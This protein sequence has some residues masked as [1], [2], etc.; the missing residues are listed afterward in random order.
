MALWLQAGSRGGLH[1]G[2]GLPRCAGASLSL[3]TLCAVRAGFCSC[4]KTPCRITP[5]MKAL[6]E[7]AAPRIMKRLIP[8]AEF[9]SDAVSQSFYSLRRPPLGVSESPMN[10]G[11]SV[12]QSL[13]WMWQFFAQGFPLPSFSYF[14]TTATLSLLD[15]RP[16]LLCPR[17]Q[18]A[19]QH[20]TVI[21]IIRLC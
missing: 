3:R 17:L 4:R 14:L 11:P 6:N 5:P 8:F 2:R 15:V 21:F 18:L 10:Q 20:V 16:L 1:S 9:T 12:F 7:N 19:G 13:P